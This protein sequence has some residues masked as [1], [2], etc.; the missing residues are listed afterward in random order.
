VQ[1]FE[2]KFW[3]AISDSHLAAS[4]SS[5]FWKKSFAYTEYER[6][7]YIDR[8]FEAFFQQHYQWQRPVGRRRPGRT[9]LKGRLSGN[10]TAGEFDIAIY[11]KWESRI[12]R[13]YS[14]AW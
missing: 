11:R 13:L 8:I 12:K 14:A 10:W 7:V 3:K 9:K 6:N 1:A 4:S 5:T 2:Q